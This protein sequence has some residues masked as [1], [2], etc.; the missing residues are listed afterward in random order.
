MAGATRKCPRMEG[1]A[2]SRHRIEPVLGRQLQLIT[3][4]QLLAAGL[5]RKTIESWCARERLHRIHRGVYCAH[6]PPYGRD[7]IWLAAVLA[8]GPEAMLSHEPAAIVQG[9]LSAG[10]LIPHVIAPG[11][12]GRSRDGIVVHAGTID[13]RDRRKVGAIACTSADRTLIDL[14]P[15]RSEAELEQIL[16]AAE[17]LGLLKRQRLAELLVD[18]RGQ[19]GIHRLA[20]VVDLA[21]VRANSSLEALFLPLWRAAGIPRS[22]VNHPVAVPVGDSPLCVD[23]AWPAIRMAVEADSQRFHGDWA[24]AERDRERDQALALAGW[25]C[26]RFVRKVVAEDTGRAAERLRRLHEVRLVLVDGGSDRA[27]GAARA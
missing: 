9:F 25:A 21:P 20:A 23:F 18:R 24:Q 19:P 8:C 14:A 13:P 2:A 11:G 15:S 27:P 22:L 6:S 16:V 4:P 7:Q 3:T 17:S 10:S 5:S 1:K 12:R 26:H